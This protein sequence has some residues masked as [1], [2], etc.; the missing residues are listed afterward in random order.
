MHHGV[1][2]KTSVAF[3]VTFIKRCDLYYGQSLLNMC[4]W[5][6]HMLKWSCAERQTF[7]QMTLEHFPEEQSWCA[8]GHSKSWGDIVGLSI[9]IIG[10]FYTPISVTLWWS[11]HNGNVV[12]LLWLQLPQQNIE[13]NLK[14]YE[15]SSM[16]HTWNWSVLTAC[17]VSI[18]NIGEARSTTSSVCG[19]WYF[20]LNSNKLMKLFTDTMIC[21]TTVC[22][23]GANSL[24]SHFIKSCHPCYRSRNKA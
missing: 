18:D 16:Y 1:F 21:L 12:H 15:A 13:I 9:N 14:L 23:T 8:I 5:W 7:V 22:H 10:A 6:Y 17:V 11:T 3:V 2:S 24:G 20:H 19:S 4:K